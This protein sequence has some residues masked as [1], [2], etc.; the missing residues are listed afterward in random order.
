M[1]S[2][3]ALEV[4]HGP[5][6]RERVLRALRH[7]AADLAPD[8]AGVRQLLGQLDALYEEVKAKAKER[9]LAGQAIQEFGLAAARD[10]ERVLS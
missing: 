10:P 9:L 8:D 7:L 2:R 4:S 6:E 5:G 1:G 3:H